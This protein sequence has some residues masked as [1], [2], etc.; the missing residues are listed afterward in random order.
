MLQ[1]KVL[2]HK[3]AMGLIG[4]KTTTCPTFLR[5]HTQIPHEKGENNVCT[6]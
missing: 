6:F 2:L 1:E 3:G 4:G 5:K